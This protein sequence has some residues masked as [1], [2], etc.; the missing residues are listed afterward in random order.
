MNY[1]RYYSFFWNCQDFVSWFLKSLRV[2]IQELDPTLSDRATG[3]ETVS[4][5]G[6]SARVVSTVVRGIHTRDELTGPEL[7][8]RI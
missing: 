1:G 7:S 5:T 3:S 4:G 6:A 2:S 8:K